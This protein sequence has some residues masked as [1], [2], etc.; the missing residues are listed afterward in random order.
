M[1]LSVGAA[2][3]GPAAYAVATTGTG[4]TGSIPSAGPAGAGF[5]PNGMH[6]FGGPGGGKFLGNGPGPNG[7]QFPGGQG[8]Q[9]NQGGQGQQFPGGQG[10]Q[11]PG[12]QGGTNGGQDDPNAQSPGGKNRGMNNLLDASKPGPQVQ[13]LL[14]QD[15]SA[16]RWAAAA[17]GSQNAAGYQLAT[18]DPV[19]AIGGF[20]GSD[21]APT[22]AQFQAYVAQHKI[23]YFIGG[24]IG[25]PANG[26]ADEGSKITSWVQAH[27]QAQTVDDAAVYDLTAPTS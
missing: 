17:I 2:L 16:Y 24:S 8:G 10:G 25:M 1:T 6:F 21:P 9:S 7:L 4:H 27:Y 22:L 18:G 26:G 23:H 5:G 11:F 15:A 3:V 20:N 14:K 19:M 12:G 13:A